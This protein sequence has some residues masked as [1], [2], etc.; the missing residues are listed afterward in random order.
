MISAALLAAA[1]LVPELASG[2][3]FADVDGDGR[4]SAGDR[5][6][7]GVAVVWESSIWTFTGE[8][9]RYLFLTP[10]RGLVWARAPEGFEPG[11]VWAEAGADV[12]LALRP[13]R[14]GGP[15]RFLHASDS[16]LGADGYFGPEDGT[17][18]AAT[19]AALAQ[20][21]ADPDLDFFTITGDLTADASPEAWI[22]LDELLAGA[23]VPFVPVIGNHDV[24][25]GDRLPYRER[26][27][28]SLYSFTRGGAHFVV[29]DYGLPIE[30]VGA[31]LA[32]DLFSVSAAL[33]V[34]VLTHAPMPAWADLYRTHG[35]DWIV[36]GHVHANRVIDWGGF[37]EVNGEPLVMG[38]LDGSPAGYRL[39][40]LE[41]DRLAIRHHDVVEAPLLAAV[42]PLPGGCVAGDRFLAAAE[43]GPGL[44]SLTLSVAGAPPV[45]MTPV[46]GWLYEAPLAVDDRA[47]HEAELVL[48]LADGRRIARAVPFCREVPAVVASDDWPQ[49]GRDARHHGFR[50]TPLSPPLA[51]A[52]AHALGGPTRGGSPVVEAGRLFVPV[53]DPAGGAAG[54]VVALD[55]TTG[56]RLWE[57]RVGASVHGAPAAA[58]G[59]VLFTA[60]DGT[61]HA[62]DAAS[63]AERWRADLLEGL[64]PMDGWLY[65]GPTI[66]GDVVYAGHRLRFEARDLASGALLWRTAP[67]PAIAMPN[68]HAHP[69]VFGDRVVA[70]FGRV[71]DGVVGLDATTG[72]T[73]WQLGGPP[74]YASPLLD[75]EGRLFLG[76]SDTLVRATDAASGELLWSRK[77]VGPVNDWSAGMAAAGAL[78][79]GRLYLPTMWGG[80]FAIDATDGEVRWRVD[81]APSVLHTNH[82]QSLARSFPA[83]PAVTGDIVW[84]GGADGLLRAISASD[85][86]ERWRLDLGTPILSG[87]VP[88]GNTL[89]VATWDG[90][91]RAL[92]AVAP[93]HAA[94][95]CRV[96]GDGPADTG[97]LVVHLF[98]LLLLRRRR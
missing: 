88:S 16:H 75:G 29:L 3:V 89:F 70:A 33:P 68:A 22:A 60:V 17:S 49:L 40:S 59:L 84:I 39:L 83:T 72:E 86:H 1:A 54:G 27:G 35:V 30:V 25:Y 46:G 43:A 7:A 61:L 38:G 66:A 78:A 77:L 28:P 34:V 65:A 93:T 58:S 14:R 81:A 87:V 26:F 9:G 44:R 82:Y 32:E 80:F 95:G 96:G 48:R 67:A 13:T 91:V 90:S 55:A 92:V 11:P 19:R 42:H 8:D 53:V 41:G 63:G 79:H 23:Q 24:P 50:E 15:V 94:G 10:A 74:S 12:D 45:A 73:R 20:G 57:R 6:L 2:R 71:A 76:G 31:F 51:V 97:L 69:A 4:W 5:P 36:S 64:G 21:L 37:T 52:W 56:V 62:V 47:T 98:L 85:G 18:L